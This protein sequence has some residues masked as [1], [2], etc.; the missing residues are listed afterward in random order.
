M[1]SMVV[2]GG[3]GSLPGALLGATYVRGTQYFLPGQWT[4]L[5]TGA[6]L[7]SC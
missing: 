5:A 3:L 7:L 4:F 2:I 1:F 6:G